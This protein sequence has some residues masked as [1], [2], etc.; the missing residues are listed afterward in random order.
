M[1]HQKRRTIG[2]V[3]LILVLVLLSFGGGLATERALVRATPTVVEQIQYVTG[4]QKGEPEEVNFGV[5]W[6]AWTVVD[7]YFYKSADKVKRLQGAIAGM[8][9]ST[10]DRYAAYLP[11]DENE[12]FMDNLSGAFSGIGAE[13]SQ[14]DGYPTIV[15]PLAGSPA[16]RAGIKPKDIIAKIDG[17]ETTGE[18]FAHAINRIRGEEGSTVTLS[19]VRSG[20][21]DV[22]EIAVVREKIELPNL[23][24]ALLTGPHGAYGYI[25]LSEFLEDSPKKVADAVV[26]LQKQGAKGYVLDLRNNPGGLLGSAVDISSL[27]I[28]PDVS[29]DLKNVVV[30]QKDRD[31]S[32]QT[33][34]LSHAPLTDAPLVVLINEGSASA[35][36][37]TAGALLDYGRARLVGTKSF[38]K[39]SVQELKNLTDGSSVK[40][41]V[42]HWLT[43]LNHEIDGV[44]IAPTNEVI[45]NSDEK[46][47]A[48]KPD[49]DRQLRE[50]ANLLQ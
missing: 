21:A 33:Y 38:G 36:E 35:S 13:I 24:S 37:I 6:E 48:G 3:L 17:V 30:S 16:E 27:F 25:R 7:N 10:G 49:E 31:G 12:L 42:A 19:V 29:A 9:Q 4:K 2:R 46:V 5:F 26:E 34:P 41:T 22:I 11:K 23:N 8:L 15:T 45:L 47:T 18:D 14:I 40:I 43:P 50:A 20:E 44:G 28:K 39:G 32:V 1:N